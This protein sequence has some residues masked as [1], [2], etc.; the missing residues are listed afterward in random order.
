MYQL[1]QQF[2]EELLAAESAVPN[3]NIY[4]ARRADGAIT[5]MV[6]N[7]SDEAQTAPL[8]LSGHEGDTAVITLLDAENLATDM[9][10]DLFASHTYP[11]QSMTLLVVGGGGE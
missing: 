9:G 8:V 10:H 2:G 4:A 5:V 1:Y 11:A 3:L 7:L 6:I